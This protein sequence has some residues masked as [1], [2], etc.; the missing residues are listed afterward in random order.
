MSITD[1]RAPR[2]PNCGSDHYLLMSNI[3]FPYTNTRLKYIQ[4]EESN[5]EVI[6]NKIYNLERRRIKGEYQE[7]LPNKMEREYELVKE[8]CNQVKENIYQTAYKAL[9]VKVQMHRKHENW[10]EE[11]EQGV[12]RKK[13]LNT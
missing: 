2:G 5:S 10:S 3:I 9:E 4:D 7:V 6:K 8:I 11:I 12:Q 13:T 1:V